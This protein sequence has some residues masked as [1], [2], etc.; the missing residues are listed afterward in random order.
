MGVADH[1]ETCSSTPPH[2]LTRQ[3]WSFYVKRYERIITEIFRKIFLPLHPPFQGKS[4]SFGTDT[5]RRD[6]ELVI[7]M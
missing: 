7:C 2:V 3:I 5:D 4:R 6:V 1:Q